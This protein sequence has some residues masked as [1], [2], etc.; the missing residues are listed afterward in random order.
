M[1][2]TQGGEGGEHDKQAPGYST[3]LTIPMQ[4]AACHFVQALAY[5]LQCAKKYDALLQWEMC[6]VPRGPKF[7][8]AVWTCLCIVM[9]SVKGAICIVYK[10]IVCRV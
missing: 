7:Y 9:F 10:C 3:L 8:I 1:G 5:V 2:C 4:Y 6:S